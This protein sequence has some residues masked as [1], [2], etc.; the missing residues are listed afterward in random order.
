VTEIRGK[1]FEQVSA[2]KKLFDDGVLTSE[3]FEEQKSAIKETY[4][5]VTSTS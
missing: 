3:E 1:S 2:L 4:L 5:A